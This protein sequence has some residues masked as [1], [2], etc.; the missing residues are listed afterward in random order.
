MVY[1]FPHDLVLVV[2]GVVFRTGNSSGKPL[3]FPV[4]K[5]VRVKNQKFRRPHA[6]K[7]VVYNCPHDL[8]LVVLG[9]FF[10]PSTV[11][12]MFLH[13]CIVAAAP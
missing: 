4:L 11:S 10:F 9:V 3:L 1:N 6:K 2:L 5:A 7:Q 13:K 8:V 12:S